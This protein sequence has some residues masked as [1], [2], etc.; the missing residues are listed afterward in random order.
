MKK[1]SNL[2]QWFWKWHF[3]AGVI[4]LP[5]ILILAITGGIYLFK[6]D[7][8]K[9]KQESIKTVA[10]VGNPI[11]YQKQ[12]ELANKQ[13]HKAPTA[14]VLSKNKGQATEFITG[15]FSHKKSLFINPYNSNVSGEISPKD[16]NMHTVR[17]IH[18][19]LLL[20][21]F[22]TKIVELIASWMV[23][24]I[25]TGLYIWWPA[26]G[27]NIK[28]FFIPRFKA[29]KQILYRD[30]HAITGFWFS[31]LLLL[32]LAGGFPWT[33]VFGDNF[34]W[35]QKTTNT[36]FPSTWNGRQLQSTAVSKALTLDEM[37]DIAQN[38]N[39]EGEVQI[40]LPQKTNSVFS[41]SN[42]ILRNL[43][44]QKKYHFDLY[45]GKQILQHN[46][47][48]VG[49]LMRGR[50]WVMAFHQGQFGT[51]NWC[52]M[53]GTAIA[54]TIMCL[55]AL[56]SY[57]K[58]K[59]KNDWSIPKVPSTFSVSSFLIGIIIFLGIIFPLFGISLLA[60]FAYKLIKN[61][62]YPRTSIH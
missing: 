43:N 23:V 57:L 35:I 52:I 21:K 10:V 40:T 8:E 60:L 19:E 18:G 17:K 53:L 27:W 26:N 15:R 3:I 58:R 50:M 6:G 59:R 29:G 45:T 16:S 32:V 12:W 51:W 28:G 1:N 49:I 37:V 7:Y 36:G 54:L 48:D 61:R 30:I 41:I 22:G 20:G 34:K 2:N 42:T 13:M 11:S 62:L 14:M 39:L 24:L 5:F 44:A 56:I 38:L 55:S 33:D 46:W 4:S 9:S 47:E 31:A 25:I